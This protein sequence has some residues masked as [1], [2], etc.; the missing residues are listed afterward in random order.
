MVEED[1]RSMVA[2]EQHNPIIG[3]RSTVEDNDAPYPVATSPVRAVDSADPTVVDNVVVP[4]AAL[5]VLRETVS[6]PLMV[7]SDSV[8]SKD[9]PETIVVEEDVHTME[10]ERDARLTHV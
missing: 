3:A 4:L 7:V 10:E 8:Q 6:V 5:R 1:A 9:A 2:P